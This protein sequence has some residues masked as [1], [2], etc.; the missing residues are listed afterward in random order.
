MENKRHP[1]A[2]QFKSLWGKTSKMRA[3]WDKFEVIHWAISEIAHN[4]A[5]KVS[6]LR[7]MVEIDRDIEAGILKQEKMALEVLVVAWN[8]FLLR[9]CLKSRDSLELLFHS[10]NTANSYGL[11]LSARSILEHVAMT[12]HFVNII[13]WQNNQMIPRA[14]MIN[15]AKQFINLTQGSTFDW[16]KLLYGKGGVRVVIA[17]KQWKRPSKE[18]IPPISQLVKTLDDEMF[19][20]QRTNYERGLL[21]LVYSALCDVVHPSWGG[22]FIYAPEIHRDM[23]EERVFDEH[24]KKVASL[25]CIPLPAVVQHFAELIETMLNYEPRMVAI[26]EEQ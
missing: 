21:Q 7:N 8:R 26:L 9:N 13:P 6:G 2:E 11:A 15:F 10:V 23:K 18:R 19:R 24:F 1:I 25:F 5:K 17:S 20:R 16:D 4:Q 22:D 3:E 14:K 12:Q